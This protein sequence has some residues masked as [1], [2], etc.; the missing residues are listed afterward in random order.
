MS[1]Y[2]TSF[3]VVNNFNIS[4]V[5][6]SMKL[7]Q[8]T[9]R[10]QERNGMPNRTLMKSR[11]GPGSSYG[12]HLSLTAI[13]ESVLPVVEASA[14]TEDALPSAQVN[15]S[16]IG[17]VK[18]ST[19]H[20]GLSSVRD[21]EFKSEDAYPSTW[22]PSLVKVSAKTIPDRAHILGNIGLASGCTSMKQT[23]DNSTPV[24]IYGG[25]EC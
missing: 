17:L 11:A 19:T 23:T 5:F 1:W 9:R 4:S 24:H 8:T 15:S 21:T 7:N 20:F 12:L 13:A 18:Y 10:T 6:M 25:H 14:G 22:P 16:A 3:Y 2:V